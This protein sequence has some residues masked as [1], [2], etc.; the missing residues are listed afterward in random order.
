MPGFKKYFM[1][2]ML[3]VWSFA[4]PAQPITPE[5]IP[6]VLQD[7]QQWV[8]F[9]KP[10][11]ACPFLYHTPSE[12]YCAWPT[13]LSVDIQDKLIFFTQNWQVFAPTILELPG[14][15]LMW[16]QNVKVNGNYHPVIDDNGIP[17]VELAKGSYRIQGFLPFSGDLPESIKIPAHTGLIQVNNQPKGFEHPRIDENNR[18]WLHHQ[19]NNLL[20]PALQIR[21][22][23]KITQSVPMEALTYI[24]L[25]VSGPAREVQLGPVLLPESLA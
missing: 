20:E 13:Q 1:T 19:E 7:W 12:R 8:L 4:S 25:D 23:R 15:T 24:E 11:Y 10:E 9:E 5:Q 2:L 6:P 21:V 14:E 17:K 18:L 3:M 22:F 16:P